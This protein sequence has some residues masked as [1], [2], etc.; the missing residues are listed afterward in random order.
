MVG[1]ET[2]AYQTKLEQLE[3]KSIKCVFCSAA[4]PRVTIVSRATIPSPF[5]QIWAWFDWLHR[6]PGHYR[7]WRLHEAQMKPST[8]HLLLS[9]ISTGQLPSE[10]GMRHSAALPRC[11]ALPPGMHAQLWHFAWCNVSSIVEWAGMNGMQVLN[12]IK[13][14]R[15]K[16]VYTH[17]RT[18]HAAITKATE[19]KAI[20]RVNNSAATL[21]SRSSPRKKE[22]YIHKQSITPAA[23]PRR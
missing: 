9:P 21:F 6:R 18:Q 15:H 2:T 12:N 13:K 19:A 17:D 1:K 5:M 11:L 4:A 3:N 10:N 7:S 16:K 22:R 20:W 8:I 23:R 14:Y